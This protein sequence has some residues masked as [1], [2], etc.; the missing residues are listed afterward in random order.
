MLSVRGISRVCG[1]IL[2][3]A[4]IALAGCG[5]GGGGGGL[6]NPTVRFFNGSPDS[7]ALNFLLDDTVE[8]ALLAY[9]E[10]TP[11]FESV[12]DRVRDL[13]IQED[14]TSVDLWNEIVDLVK[15][16]HYLICS[17]G[18]E[19]FGTE[20]LK[21]IRTLFTEIDRTAPNG[22]RVRLI[23]VHGYN[24][25]TGLE[26][27]AIDFQTP[28]DNPQ[29]SADNIAYA[30]SRVLEVDA[31]NWTFEARREGTETILTSQ[32]I[33]LGGGKIY[34]AFVLGVENAAGIQAPRIEFVE[35]QT[36]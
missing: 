20:N 7:T 36:D 13:R 4:G 22:S 21:R 18:L 27:P 32:N 33:T 14:G 26:T 25:E 35:L 11:D 9:L 34:A 5:G 10:S 2:A 28:G 8:A 23:I 30:S 17:I 19:N 3:I 24:R 29:F 6:P 31:G 15:D 12:D 16:K 1:G